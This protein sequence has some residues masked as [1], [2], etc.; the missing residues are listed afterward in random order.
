MSQSTSLAGKTGFMAGS[1]VSE[2]AGNVTTGR[3]TVK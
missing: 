3:P 1:E 2:D